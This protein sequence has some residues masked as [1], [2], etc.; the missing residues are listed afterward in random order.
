MTKAL[1]TVYGGRVFWLW[2]TLGAAL[3][4]VLMLAVSHPVLAQ[5]GQHPSHRPADHWRHYTHRFWQCVGGANTDRGHD[6]K[7]RDANGLPDS[8]NHRW[9]L[10]NESS[11]MYEYI[12]GAASS[13]YTIPASAEGKAIRVNVS[14]TDDADNYESR[15]SNPTWNV[16]ATMPSDVGTFASE[17]RNSDFP[18]ATSTTGQVSVG[19]EPRLQRMLFSVRG[20]TGRIRPR[21]TGTGTR[22][23]TSRVERTIALPCWEGTTATTGPWSTPR[24]SESTTRQGPRF[25]ERRT[26]T[27]SGSRHGS[28]SRPAAATT[29]TSPLGQ[30]LG[31]AA[32][33][34]SSR[35]CLWTSPPTHRPPGR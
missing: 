25:V 13:T 16:V 8:Y 34:S 30:V 19:G 9:L 32:T 18:E 27:L 22:L 24:Y 3:L 1:R 33:S 28:I 26:I 29:I 5:S 23:T 2:S 20:V 4:A 21:V 35:R 10:Y 11:H 7:I 6:S 12:S 31:R 14:F 17:R 15:T